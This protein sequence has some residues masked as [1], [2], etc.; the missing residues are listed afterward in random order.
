MKAVRGLR[1]HFEKR[2]EEML[3]EIFL[4]IRKSF[5]AGKGFGA[6]GSFEQVEHTAKK[7]E[8]RFTFKD[9]MQ[10]SFMLDQNS[11]VRPTARRSSLTHTLTYSLT[12]SHSHPHTYSHIRSHALTRTCMRSCLATPSSWIKPWRQRAFTV[13]LAMCQ[14]C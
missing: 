3:D 1:Y 9:N 6:D 8:V 7:V 4:Q 2:L 13:T 14:S 10:E 12:Y 11:S 5:A